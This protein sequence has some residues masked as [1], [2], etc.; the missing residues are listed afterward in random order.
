[1]HS[2][3]SIIENQR[4]FKEEI[5]SFLKTEF[6]ETKRELEK[7]KTKD[8]EINLYKNKLSNLSKK[9]NVKNGIEK[10]FISENNI[11][12]KFYA[13]WDEENNEVIILK[14]ETR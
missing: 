4:Q 6:K 2:R 12:P 13:W 10:F 3:K 9:A 5:I 8:E 7:I 14:Y 11:Y 1:M